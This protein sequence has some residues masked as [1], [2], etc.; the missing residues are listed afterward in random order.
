MNWIDVKDKL[1]DEGVEVLCV[2]TKF[3]Q[4]TIDKSYHESKI[5]GDGKKWWRS[6]EQI[7]YALLWIEGGKWGSWDIDDYENNADYMTVIAWSDRLDYK[8]Q[9]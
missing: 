3:G 4:R 7:H 8:L 9:E 6:G 1:P 5:D 2:I